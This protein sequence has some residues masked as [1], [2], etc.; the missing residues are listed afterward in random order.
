MGLQL[1]TGSLDQWAVDFRVSFGR[2]NWCTNVLETEARSECVAGSNLP[3]ALISL[4]L[5]IVLNFP[6]SSQI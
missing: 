5:G 2:P 6:E 3:F 4:Y 1:L